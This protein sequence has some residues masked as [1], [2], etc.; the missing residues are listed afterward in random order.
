MALGSDELTRWYPADEAKV[1][2]ITQVRAEQAEQR[3]AVLAG[4]E[5][6]WATRVRP[7]EQSRNQYRADLIET[8]RALR[9]QK[10]W[11]G[12]LGLLALLFFPLA[13]REA[14]DL[15]GLRGLFLVVG[16]ALFTIVWVA[17]P[18]WGR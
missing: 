3:A 13:C 6:T 8:S 1:V 12:A 11:T 15:I 10:I 2:S 16:I 14:T 7:I 17:L 18:K 5:A 4:R 9:I